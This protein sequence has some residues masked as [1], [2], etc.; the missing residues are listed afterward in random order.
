MIETVKGEEAARLFLSRT[1]VR[2]G[3]RGL[4][5]LRDL[6]VRFAEIPYENISKIIK[7]AASADACD[8]MRLPT[9]VMTDHIE[10]GFGGTCFSLTFLLE[11][12]LKA[13]G[14]DCY[15]VMADMRSGRNVHCLVVVRENRTGHL[16]DPGYALYEVLEMPPHGTCRVECPHA[17]VEVERTENGTYSLW[18]RDPSGRKWRYRFRDEP[19]GDSEFERHWIA[20][21][22]KP[23]LHNVCLTKMTSGGHIYLRKDFFKFTSQRGISKRRLKHDIETFIQQEFGIAGEWTE[24]A[25]DILRERRREVW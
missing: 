4:A 7:S 24:I 5:F 16:I 22:G 11:R 6:A 25:Q 18:T 21:F 8:A 15:K 1:E 17:V 12:M 2:P 14:F 19:V 9:E 13:L 20:S 3:G 10:R 23:T